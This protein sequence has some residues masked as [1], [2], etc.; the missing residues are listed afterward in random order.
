VGAHLLHIDLNKHSKAHVFR[1]TQEGIVFSF[2]YGLDI[3][4]ENG[5][6]LQSSAWARANM[7]LS[8]L[9][10][11]VFVD[12]TNVPVELYEMTEVSGAARRWYRRGYFFF[13]Q[14]SIQSI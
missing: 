13:T 3:M 14:R 7:F 9:F 12:T 5:F 2:R 8:D 10:T 4:R 1:A 6:N 11:A